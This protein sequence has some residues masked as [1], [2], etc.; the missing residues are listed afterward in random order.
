MWRGVSSDV[1]FLDIRKE[2]LTILKISK[3]RDSSHFSQRVLKSR[4]SLI[5]EFWDFSFAVVF[6]LRHSIF[7]TA[8]PLLEVAN[9]TNFRICK[10]CKYISFCWKAF[11]ALPYNL[12]ANS[13]FLKVNSKKRKKHHPW[14]LGF[15]ALISGK[16]VPV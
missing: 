16:V 2:I 5:S 9:P 14:A 3:T 15:L 8:K 1:E 12:F 13:I 7:L 11:K 6:K 10:W 4:N